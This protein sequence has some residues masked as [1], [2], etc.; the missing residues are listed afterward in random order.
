M[1]ECV[2]TLNV[3]LTMYYREN[4]LPHCPFELIYKIIKTIVHYNF[5][6]YTILY[7]NIH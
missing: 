2:D 3:Y 1:A 4:V 6:T 7:N 5:K